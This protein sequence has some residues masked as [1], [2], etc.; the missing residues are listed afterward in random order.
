MSTKQPDTIEQS[1]LFGIYGKIRVEFWD[2]WITVYDS[3]RESEI[4][5]RT[6]SYKEINLKDSTKIKTHELYYLL[7]GI[8]FFLFWL[9]MRDIF[10]LIMGSI[11]F[12][13]YFRSYQ[14]HIILN[15]GFVLLDDKKYPDIIERIRKMQQ[16]IRKEE[17]Y[18]IYPYASKENEVIRMQELKDEWIISEK[19]L[20][21]ILTEIEVYDFWW[22]QY[23]NE[24]EIIS[25][26]L[27]RKDILW[28]F[29]LE[30]IVFE[31]ATLPWWIQSI[32]WEIHL[33]VDCVYEFWLRWDKQSTD[34][35]TEK[36]WFY[37]LGDDVWTI[38]E[39]GRS[40]FA[41]LEN[42]PNKDE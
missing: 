18:K 5:K 31:W 10:F 1:T 35:E 29:S 33:T 42:H 17:E 22:L 7:V 4:K 15:Y 30:N 13:L 2:T 26:L 39:Y 9:L 8:V 37:T 16:P 6:Y 11:F 23:K 40:F 28:S 24:K 32:S 36:A 38:E 41:K 27:E 3:Y 25:R 21:D 34:P 20:A 14:K 12:F 19:E